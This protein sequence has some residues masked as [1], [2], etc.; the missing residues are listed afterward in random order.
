MFRE[1]LAGSVERQ[2]DLTIVGQYTSA[3]EALAALKDV[4]NGVVLLDVNLGNER[5]MDFVMGAKSRNFSGRILVVTAGMSDQEA[6]NLVQA[7]VSGIIHKHHSTESLFNT[8]RQVARGEFFLENKY[9]GS[10]F[11]SVDRSRQ[12]DRPELDDRER[13]V[14]RLLMKGMTNREIAENMLVTEGAIKALLHQVFQK[15]NVRTRA[16]LVKVVLEQYR[17]EL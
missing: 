5:A 11:R 3:T 13:T 16:Q 12:S 9:L 2:P 15:L 1:G 14:L 10:L 4:A 17:D 7:G 8:I 6:V